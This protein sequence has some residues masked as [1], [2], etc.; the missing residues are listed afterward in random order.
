[1]AY[2]VKSTALSS[3]VVGSN[4]DHVNVLVSYLISVEVDIYM[5][6]LCRS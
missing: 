5:V 6:V 2:W 4:P 3:K 1:M